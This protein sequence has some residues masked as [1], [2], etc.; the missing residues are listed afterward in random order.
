MGRVPGKR[1]QEPGPFAFLSANGTAIRAE[2]KRKRKWVPEIDL[3][4]MGTEKVTTKMELYR[5]P[6]PAP[7]PKEA[8]DA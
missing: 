4:E 2:I 3:E 7:E 1:L 6:K 5:V 8:D